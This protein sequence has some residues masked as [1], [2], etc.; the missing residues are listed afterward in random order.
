MIRILGLRIASFHAVVTG[1]FVGGTTASRTTQTSFCHPLQ[2]RWGGEIRAERIRYVH[3]GFGE[4]T[5]RV[6]ERLPSCLAVRFKRIA[7]YL[8][9]V[10][11]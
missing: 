5:I 11:V 4:V 1:I 2:I 6:M 9:W 10:F 8:R 7:C 3:G